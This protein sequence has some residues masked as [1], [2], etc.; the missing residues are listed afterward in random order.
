MTVGSPISDTATLSGGF[1]PT[2][3]ITF[4]LF[5]DAACSTEV[6][7]STVSVNGNGNYNSGNFTPTTAGTYLWTASY[8][9]D[10]NNKPVSTSCGDANESSVV[11][12]AQPGLTTNATTPVTVNSP[13]SDT[14]TLSGGFN[15]TGT[16]TFHLFSDAAC[17]TEVFTSTVT[18]NGNGNY[19]SGNFTPTTAGTYLWTASYSGDTNNKPVSTSCGDANESSVVNPA[20]PGLTTNATTP[21]TVDSPISDTATLSGGFNPTGTITFHLFSD[22]ACSTQVFTSTVSVNGNGNYNSG[23]F[24]PNAVGTY[25]WT[26]SYSGDINNK[27]V[28]TS[29]GDAN[30]SSVVNP[31]PVECHHRAVLVPARLRHGDSRRRW[32][33]DR[34]RHVQLVRPERHHLQ[35]R[36]R[37]HPGGAAQ[38]RLGRH[39]EHDV[40]GERRDQHHLPM[41]RRLPRRCH[42]S[43]LDQQLHREHHA[44]HRQRLATPAASNPR[45]YQPQ[46]GG[47]AGRG[48]G[49]RSGHP[50]T[51]HTATQRRASRV[52]PRHWRVQGDTGVARPPPLTPAAPVN[53]RAVRHV[54]GLDVLVSVSAERWPT[55]LV[56]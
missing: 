28:S 21:V 31:G 36:C 43:A 38:R 45:R 37:V 8:S 53:V 41:G 24:T 7:T 26:A 15:P 25:L 6:F 20:Q 16:I 49:L 10:T 27:P 33:A 47:P 39:V 2:G 55:W 3:T 54:E 14:A 56:L 48:G 32:H 40:L 34:N 22:A 42:P 29:C 4:H 50:W 19:N 13:I 46:N 11:N 23:N 17:S 51:P 35:R 52:R 12:P 1:N 18:V 5:S 30:E 44:D 9:G